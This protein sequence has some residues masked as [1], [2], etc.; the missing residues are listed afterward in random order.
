[1]TETQF[2]QDDLC[3]FARRPARCNGARWALLLGLSVAWFGAQAGKP[4]VEFVV[5][6]QASSGWTAHVTVRHADQG[7][8]H[9]ADAWRIVDPDGGVLGTRTLYHPHEAEQP[10]TRSLGDVSIASSVA[11]VEVQAHDKVH[12]WGTGVRVIMAQSEGPQF[13][14]RR[15]N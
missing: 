12:G 6:E 9:Y 2:V 10:F 5:M 1:M 4:V 11:W 3:S 13:R 15:R 7:W 8:D 14:V